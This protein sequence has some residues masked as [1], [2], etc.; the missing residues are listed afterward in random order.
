MEWLSFFV[1]AVVGGAVAIA[2]RYDLDGDYQEYIPRTLTVTLN[3][4]DRLWSSVRASAQA[5]AM[6][7]VEATLNDVCRELSV[8][9]TAAAAPTTPV[10]PAIP[11]SAF[12]NPELN[13]L[14]QEL[15]ASSSPSES[16]A[17][18]SARTKAAAMPKER[19]VVYP[20]GRGYLT[21]SQ[22]QEIGN[23]DREHKK[24]LEASK[25]KKSEELEV[26]RAFRGIIGMTYS[27]ARKLVEEQGFALHVLSVEKDGVTMKAKEYSP[28][29]LGVEL[30]DSDY[31]Y[32]ANVPS[33]GAKIVQLVNV[34]GMV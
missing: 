26:L 33:A 20:T 10:S 31:D 18:R 9:P 29:T 11:V 19:P 8:G 4:P 23:A 12:N 3:V 27:E 22:L 5:S 13:E 16:D 6:A 1:G 25:L 32:D 17:V 24:K 14:Y 2:F 34:G 15:T 7:E 30:D 21:Q 28:T